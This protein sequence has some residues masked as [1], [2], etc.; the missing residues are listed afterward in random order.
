MSLGSANPITHTNSVTR[1]N[2]AIVC[3]L[4]SG[5]LVLVLHRV[6]TKGACVAFALLYGFTSGGLISLQSACVA[7]ITKNMR[8]IGVMIGVMMAVCSVGALTGNPIGGALTSMKVGGV[9][10]WVD[11]GGVLLLAG[12]LVLLAARLAID[13]R[14]V[15]IV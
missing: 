1:Y 8:I 3:S 15:Q 12:T 7:Q 11:F 13:P 9:S 6:H 4:L 10:A 5:I 14:L 2:V